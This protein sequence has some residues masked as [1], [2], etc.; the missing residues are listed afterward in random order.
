[1]L[2]LIIEDATII[3]SWWGRWGELTDELR[4]ARAVAAED[5]KNIDQN[6]FFK[7]IS[8]WSS[9]N[10]LSN[11]QWNILGPLND[12]AWHTLSVTRSLLK[13]CNKAMDAYPRKL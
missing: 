2:D 8:R 7:L 9:Q 10:D 4:R 3:K 6:R 12:L 1:M 5:S 11:Y 13:M